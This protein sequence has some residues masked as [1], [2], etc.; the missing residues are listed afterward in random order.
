MSPFAPARPIVRRAA[1]PALAVLAAVAVA[2][3]AAAQQ[4]V[5]FTMRTTSAVEG[6]DATPSVVK[7]RTRGAV[8]RFDGVQEAGAERGDFG[9]GA[10][11]LI[12]A[13]GRRIQ[14]VMPGSKQ[15]ME[16]KFDDST[17]AAIKTVA[18][19]SGAVADLQ[20]SGQSLG[21]GGTVNGMP[22][23]RH[24]LTTDF[25]QIV[26]AGERPRRMHVVEEYW[27]SD[28]LR[29]VVDPLEQLGRTLG[30]RGGYAKSPYAVVGGS[31]VN[32]LLSRRMAEQQR[33]FKGF[34][35]KTVTTSEETAPDGTVQKSVTTT[36]LSDVQRASFDA[37]LFQ[38]PDGY[39]LFDASAFFANM[40]AQMKN[41][42]KDN[43]KNAAAQSA[44]DA[45]KG[46]FGGFLKKKKP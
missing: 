26:A 31:S 23:S 36:E 32:D 34:P 22:T 46:A 6:G 7:V 12:D 28:A 17:A 11:T 40:E 14:I 25:S 30:G 13:A 8:M 24:R 42:V 45:V 44:K 9:E 16:L 10:Y 39:A 33:M 43:A 41:A 38:V 4:G 3:P 29:D 18:A 20:V 5:G 1:L 35:V 2:A 27:V 37:A 15:Y 19:T 21:S